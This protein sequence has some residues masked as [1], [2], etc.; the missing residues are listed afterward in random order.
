MDV[1]TRDETQETSGCMQL[2]SNCLL[3]TSK[4]SNEIKNL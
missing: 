1:G 2:L 3:M 4:K